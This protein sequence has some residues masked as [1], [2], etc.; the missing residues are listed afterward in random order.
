MSSGEAIK[1]MVSISKNL[2]SMFSMKSK[3]A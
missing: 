2:Y 3:R 1:S